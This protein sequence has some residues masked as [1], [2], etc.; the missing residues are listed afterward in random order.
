VGRFLELTGI[1]VEFQARTRVLAFHETTA[2]QAQ[3]S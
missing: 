2:Q 1:I 3:D